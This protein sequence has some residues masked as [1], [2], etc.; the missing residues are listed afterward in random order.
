MRHLISEPCEVI[1][2]LSR[3]RSCLTV[4]RAAGQQTMEAKLLNFRLR[5]R[6]IL[7]RPKMPLHERMNDILQCR[8][9]SS[10]T[11]TCYVRTLLDF[12]K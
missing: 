6:P 5:L 12:L 8:F 10:Q 3:Q 1:K 9:I 2:Q 11:R 7:G 4:E